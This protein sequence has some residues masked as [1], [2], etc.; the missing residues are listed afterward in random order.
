M[1][2]T[3]LV[4]VEPGVVTISINKPHVRNAVDG[5]TM[6]A[7]RDAIHRHQDDGQTRVFILTGAGGAFSSGADMTAQPAVPKDTPAETILATLRACYHP[8]LLAI[9][10]TPWPVIAAVDGPAAGIG[11]DMA[12]AC[13]LRFASD[14]ARFSSIF[15]KVGL[16]P[17]GGGTWTL[18]RL[19][20]Q[21]RAL[22]MIYTARQVP[23]DEALAWGLINRVLAADKL[24]EETRAF[25]RNL[26][27][28][29]PHALRRVKK[30]FQAS[31]TGSYDEALQ[32]EAENQGEIFQTEDGMEGFLAFL[33]KRP[34][35]WTGR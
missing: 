33:Q 2:D 26:A 31:Q 7:I 27:T 10:N 32:R 18:P 9:R 17:D 8:A 5:H 34:P 28:Q 1:S 22:D 20:G 35:R 24:M 19:I 12:L 25:A 4:E 6:L 15:M 11:F 3:V 13:D 30:V 29:S 21:T 16:I 14:R 23:A